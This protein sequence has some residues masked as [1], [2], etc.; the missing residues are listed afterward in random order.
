[1]HDED[2]GTGRTTK[3]MQE[4]PKGAIFVWCAQDLTY[5]QSLVRQIKREDLV[6]ERPSFFNRPW[7]RFRGLSS[8]IIIDHAAFRSFTADQRDGYF[9][10][11]VQQEAKAG[12][13]A[14]VAGGSH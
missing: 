12:S 2:R 1:M 11:M 13:P 7:H 8:P 4:A 6:L 9:E 5:P 10:C 14:T 3:Q